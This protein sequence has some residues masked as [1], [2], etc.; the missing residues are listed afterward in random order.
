MRIIFTRASTHDSEKLSLINP[1]TPIAINVLDRVPDLEGT[2]LRAP[3][4]NRSGPLRM[5]RIGVF[6]QQRRNDRD[7]LV[8]S[9]A[10]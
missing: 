10:G 4:T 2:S 8:V 1:V 7:A 3:N 9:G 5:R 6:A